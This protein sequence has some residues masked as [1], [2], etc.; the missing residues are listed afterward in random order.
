MDFIFNDLEFNTFVKNKVNSKMN[1]KRLNLNIITKNLGLTYA[2]VMRM[3]DS[4]AFKLSTFV[5]LCNVLDTPPEYF[6]GEYLKDISPGGDST[7]TN[8]HG[9][10][11]TLKNVGVNRSVIVDE[12]RKIED[13]DE[14]IKFYQEKSEFLEDKI[15]WLK[16]K[17]GLEQENKKKG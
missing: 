9:S 2:G 13:I 12:G 11:N 6:I 8:V 16:E 4:G 17:Y 15:A 14:R 3:F 7:R 1:E 5:K 10:N